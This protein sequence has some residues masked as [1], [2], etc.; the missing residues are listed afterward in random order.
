MPLE[1]SVTAFAVST[2]VGPSTC[3]AMSAALPPVTSS[4][5][6]AS[7]AV[8]SKVAGAPAVASTRPAPDADVVAALGRFER[9]ALQDRVPCMRLLQAEPLELQSTHLSFQEFYAAR[10]VCSGV[11]RRAARRQHMAHSFVVS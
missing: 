9:M 6:Y 1:W 5:P 8:T 11:R 4:F 3:K 2:A 10:A 7:R